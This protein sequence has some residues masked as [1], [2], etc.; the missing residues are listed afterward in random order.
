MNRRY[1]LVSLF[2]LAHT[3]LGCVAPDDVV[4]HAAVEEVS[5]A[6]VT[7]RF[8]ALDQVCETAAR[9]PETLAASEGSDDFSLG[10]F[11][12]CFCC[13]GP[14][15]CCAACKERNKLTTFSATPQPR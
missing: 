5:Q 11:P 3:L 10:C 6:L 4:E 9:A 8:A 7:P 15:S 1:N 2:L 14:G 12:C 13:E